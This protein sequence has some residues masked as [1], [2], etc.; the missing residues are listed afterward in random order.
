MKRILLIALTFTFSAYSQ[1]QT[2]SNATA[3]ATSTAPS[4]DDTKA[5][6]AEKM[7]K[8]NLTDEQ[9]DKMKELNNINRRE[10]MAIESDSTLSADQKQKKIKE[11]RKGQQEKLKSILTSEQYEQLKEM[12]K[13]DD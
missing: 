10:K 3:P 8:L 12:R 11:L 6:K 1:A 13:N 2:T 5:A 9:R 4:K 7:K